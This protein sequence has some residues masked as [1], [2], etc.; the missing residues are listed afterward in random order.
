MQCSSTTP[1]E[2]VRTKRFV[3]TTTARSRQRCLQSCLQSFGGLQKAWT[4]LTP[5]T[6]QDVPTSA[7]LKGV[8]W[9]IL[10]LLPKMWNRNQFLITM[11]ERYSKLTRDIP[12]SKKTGFCAALTFIDHYIMSYSIL[13]FPW[14]EIELQFVDKLFSS[15][16]PIG[17]QMNDD[18]SVSPKNQGSIRTIQQNNSCTIVSTRKLTPISLGSIPTAAK[19][20][21]IQTST[22]I[23]KKYFS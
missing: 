12:A 20:F 17:C 23:Y 21:I 4:L 13:S 14:T 19:I 2:W 3:T 16:Q 9:K 15:S 22:S 5:A 10:R 8:S 11:T 1:G 7:H 6:S 18:H